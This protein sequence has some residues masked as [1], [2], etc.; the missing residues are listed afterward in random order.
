MDFFELINTRESIRDYD[1]EAIIKKEVLLR[2]INAGRIAP[3]ASNKQPWKFLVI[4]SREMLEKIRPCYHRDWFKDAPHI[5]IVLGDK[6]S[7]WVRKKDGY[8]SIETDLTIAMDHIILAAET[9]GVAT[10]W[11]S[12]FDNELLRTA[13]Q[14]TDSQIVFNITPLG[15]PR[16][17]F[18]KKSDK[19]RKS[20]EEVVEFL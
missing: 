8:N 1:P 9:V 2:I 19:T 14:L 17:G 18:Q 13:L 3:S 5:L 16:H 7:S 11:I 6:S 4:S 15:Y 20:I 10:C 12:A